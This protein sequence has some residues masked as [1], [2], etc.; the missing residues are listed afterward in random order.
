VPKYDVHL[1]PVVR[2]T[3]RNIEAESPKDACKKAEQDLSDEAI[4]SAICGSS[5]HEADFEGK[6]LQALVDVQGDEDYSES[7][8]LKPAGEAW[9]RK[10]KNNQ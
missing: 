10:E 6:V 8:W 4:R 9:V 1:F 3:V 2:F 7:S 5:E